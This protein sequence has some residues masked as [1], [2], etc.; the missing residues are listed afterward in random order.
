M[1][2]STRH[3]CG[4]HRQGSVQV[5]YAI[6]ANPEQTLPT[7]FIAFPTNAVCNFSLPLSTLHFFDLETTHAFVLFICHIDYLRLLPDGARDDGWPFSV[8]SIWYRDRCMVGDYY[9]IYSQL[10]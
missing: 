9:R 3:R 4:Y 8:A 1:R 5:R 2:E 6:L 7:W 10:I